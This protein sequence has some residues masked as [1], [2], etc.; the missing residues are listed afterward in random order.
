MVGEQEFKS[1]RD[2][3]LLFGI[4]LGLGGYMGQPWGNITGLI[5]FSGVI[6]LYVLRWYASRP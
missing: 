5:A 4:G 1:M 3:A 2:G 6:F